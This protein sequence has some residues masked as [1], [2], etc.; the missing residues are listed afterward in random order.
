MPH[1]HLDTMATVEGVP[2][3]NRLQLARFVVSNEYVGVWE[4]DQSRLWIPLVQ[5]RG[6]DVSD[7]TVSERRTPGWAIVLGIIGLF[8]FLLGLLFF[9]V[10]TDRPVPGALVTVLTT[11]GRVVRAYVRMPVG[12]VQGLLWPLSTQL[13]A[14][15]AGPSPAPGDPLP[16]P[17]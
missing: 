12:V 15:A 1:V 8:F 11:D 13:A 6:I 17:R 2:L 7:A 4:Q 3:D 9:F 5:V 14:R 10:K 16:P